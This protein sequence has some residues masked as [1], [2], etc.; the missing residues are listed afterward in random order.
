MT[1]IDPP[2]AQAPLD[3]ARAMDEL[4]SYAAWLS[5]DMRRKL[6]HDGYVIIPG[7]IDTPWLEQLRARVDLQYAEEGPH[8][9]H[10]NRGRRPEPG[11]LADMVNKGA[12]F[13]RAW[14]HPLALAAARHVLGRPFKLYCLNFRDPPP[15]TPAQRLHTDIADP[16]PGGPY[17]KMQC[18]WTLDDFTVEN[19]AT[20]AIRGS[21]L[22][23]EV[24]IAPGGEPDRV[25]P[26]EV[27]WCAPAGS[28]IIYNGSV[29]H[30]AG[31][32]AGGAHRRSLIL[33]YVTRDLDQLCDQAEYLRVRTARRLGPL[34]RWL[35]DA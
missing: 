19:G 24:P 1:I 17:P 32:N 5:D 2:G 10:E 4:A 21:H 16:V 26:E 6:D 8:G 35:L 27:R 29:W 12:V 15:G 13:D 9:H 11:K 33:A 14:S 28:L 23:A 20:R 3:D 34:Q 7:A 25:H 18:I 22:R 31:A 30:G